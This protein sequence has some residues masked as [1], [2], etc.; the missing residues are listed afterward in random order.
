MTFPVEPGGYELWSQRWADGQ[1]GFHEGKPND[2]LTAYIE[3]LEA[4]AARARVLVPLSGK[5]VDMRWLAERGHEVVGVEFVWSAVRAFFDEWEVEPE[6]LEIGGK[7]AL[8]ARG[9]TLICSDI[10]ALSPEALGSFDVIYDRAALVAL[11]P[12]AREA[13]VAACRAVLRDQGAVFLVTFAYDQSRVPGPPFSVDSAMVHGLFAKAT[14]ELLET[15]G[16]PTSKRLIEAGVS[17]VE[18]SAYMIT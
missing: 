8:S 7:P 4:I 12:S 14:I 15:R 9:V 11:D 13:Y 2:L 5:T 1:T 18:E 10:L 16:A 17:A 6:R 3:R